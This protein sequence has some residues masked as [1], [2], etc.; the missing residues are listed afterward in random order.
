M[1]RCVEALIAICVIAEFVLL[2]APCA[3]LY[4][5]GGSASLAAAVDVVERALCRRPF[6]FPRFPSHSLSSTS[7]RGV[8]A[9]AVVLFCHSSVLSAPDWRSSDKFGMFQPGYCQTDS[10]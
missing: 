10:I 5:N 6:P 4:P 1:I 2:Y 3:S 7:A 9:E 8:L